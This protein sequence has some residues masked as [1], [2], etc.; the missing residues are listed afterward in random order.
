VFPLEL[1]ALRYFGDLQCQIYVLNGS[2]DKKAFM[3]PQVLSQEKLAIR[4]SDLFTETAT[5]DIILAT[6]NRYPDERSVVLKFSDI[7]AIDPELAIMLL[8]YPTESLEA[9][10]E[11][12]RSVLPEELER[13][14]SLNLRITGLPEDVRVDIRNL[15]SAHLGKFLSIE[16]LVRKAT[17][18][19]PK[20]IEAVFRCLR[21]DARLRIAQDAQMLKEPLQCYTEQGGCGRTAGATRFILM[22]DESVY[23]DSQKIEIQE[24]PEGLRGGAQPERLEAFLQDDITGK[25]SPGDRI[26]LN[27]ILIGMQRTGAG[28]KSTLF[29][30][31]L[32]VNSLE[33]REHEYDE[34]EITEEDVEKIKEMA[35]SGDVIRDISNSISPTIYGFEVEKEA[36]AL[37]LFGGVPKVM[38][39][40]TR[41][42]GDIHILLVGD[43]GLAKSQLLRYMAELAPRGIYT[44]GKSSS[45]A[46]LTAAAVKDEFGE[47]RWTLEA[48]ALVLADK[49]VACV[50]ELDKMSDYDRSA[51]HQIMESQIITVAKAGITATLQARCSILG[52]ANPKEGRFIA[53]EAIA[54]QID[55]PPALL[56][57][58]DLIF[59]LL[60]KPNR[61]QD[62]NIASHILKAH[63]VGEMMKNETIPQGLGEE[64]LRKERESVMPRFDRTMLRKYI[65]YAKRINPVMDDDAMVA[66][67]EEYL[68]IRGMGEGD[69]ASVPITARQLEA[70]V[71]LAEASARGR[72]SPKVEKQ[73]AER[74]I[75]IVNYYLSKV[76]Y[77]K[78]GYDID[79]ITG[80]TNRSTQVKARTLMN[81]ISDEGGKDGI[82]MEALKSRAQEFGISEEELDD[83]ITKLSEDSLIY[84]VKNGVY[85]AVSSRH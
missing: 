48:G 38:D 50:D 45:A 62:R 83:L 79:R 76:A 53:E 55:L 81:I 72:L 64:K 15:R 68:R 42:R 66:I 21:C 70:Y 27:G 25:V 56:S 80:A 52:A 74:A 69:T 4:W 59:P 30:I 57:R 85:K 11:A 32:Q 33:Y 41:I 29:N 23:I 43:P 58:F 20:L 37:Q 73:D 84:Q 78:E 39:D 47:G 12:M 71:R 9:A 26:I 10:Q 7:N 51:M 22:Q 77:G 13:K 8:D 3:I 18:V 75:R 1:L 54:S 36:F 61:V 16:G 14:V 82:E 49:G 17:E 60:D 44:S 63:R 65:S 35:S 5:D 40:G 34:I 24:S 31:A 46:G 2:V 67:M 6:A 28:P 19:R